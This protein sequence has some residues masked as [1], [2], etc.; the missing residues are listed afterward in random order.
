MSGG[1]S[2]HSGNRFHRAQHDQTLCSRCVP[3]RACRSGDSR[4]PRRLQGSICDGLWD[5]THRSELLERWGAAWRW[6]PYVSGHD[7]I[8]S[9]RG[10]AG[11]SHLSLRPESHLS[12]VFASQVDRTR[13]PDTACA[14]SATPALSRTSGCAR[15]LG[16]CVSIASNACNPGRYLDGASER[17]RLQLQE[18]AE[19]EEDYNS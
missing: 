1:R 3:A 8:P 12:S 19:L 7:P 2:V 11:R 9:S 10:R 17:C 5:N 16:Y 6:R 15:A 18:W 4:P 13:H 14:I